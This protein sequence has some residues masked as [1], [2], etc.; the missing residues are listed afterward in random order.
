MWGEAALVKVGYVVDAS[1]NTRAEGRAD[2]IYS[3]E[4]T[5]PLV[6]SGTGLL[7][8]FSFVISLNSVRFQAAAIGAWYNTCNNIGRLISDV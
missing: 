7:I 8:P 4:G 3:N 1:P 6:A 2:A 5:G